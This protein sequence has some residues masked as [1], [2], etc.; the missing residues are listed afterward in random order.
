MNVANLPVRDSQGSSAYTFSPPP[1]VRVV[2]SPLW[3]SALT[4]LMRNLAGTWLGEESVSTRAV[5]V[6]FEAPDSDSWARQCPEYLEHVILITRGDKT[7]LTF[8]LQNHIRVLVSPEDGPECLSAALKAALCKE[9]Y[10]SPVISR[11]LME[12]L[13]GRTHSPMVEREMAATATKPSSNLPGCTLSE[14]EEEV[15]QL[16]ARGLS[17]LEI[18]EHLYISEGTVKCHLVK[19]FDKLG[20]RRRSQ[21]AGALRE[22]NQSESGL[23][24]EYSFR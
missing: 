4:A 18:A 17:N 15:A 5:C 11:C 7:S 22:Y 12:N 23:A 8:A 3:T 2:G 20:V 19:V 9:H 13:W 14:R 6:V 10:T 16:V 24:T 21:I 1:A